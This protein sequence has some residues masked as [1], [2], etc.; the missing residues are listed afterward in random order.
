MYQ[1]TGSDEVLAWLR[2][3]CRSRSICISWD[4]CIASKDAVTLMQ[5][6]CGQGSDS[7][8]AND[9][10]GAGL[11]PYKKRPNGRAVYPLSGFADYLTAR[12]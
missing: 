9:R 2:R 10:C 4:D 11:I 7:F 8:L 5:A 12:A 6:F 1:P 3:E